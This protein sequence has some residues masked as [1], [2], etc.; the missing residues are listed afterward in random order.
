MKIS[1]FGAA[2]EVGRSCIMVSTDKTRILLDAGVKIGAQDEYPHLDDSMLKDIDGIVVSH[3]H[4]DH[5]GYLPHIYSAGYTG[6]TYVTKPTMELITVLISDYMRISN[7][8]NVTQSGLKKMEAAFRLYEYRKEFRINEL[9]LKF[10]PAGHILGSAMISVSDGKNTLLY[11]G[12]INTAK[13]KLFDG[14]ELKGLNADTLIT[15]STYGAPND[16]FQKEQDIIREMVKSIKETIKVGGKV[17]IPSFAVGRAQEVLLFLDDNINSGALPKVPIYVDGMINKAMRIHRHN[18]I[19]CRKELQ[20][21]ILM[22]EYDP[23]KSKNFVVVDK[24]GTRNKIVTEEESAIIVTTSGMLSGGPVFFYLS[25]L[26]GNSLNKM[27]MV[28]YQAE[29]TLGR[30]M[31]DGNRHITIDKTKIDVQLKVETYHLSAHADRKGLESVM[32]SINGLKNVFIVHGEKSK[33]ESLKEYASKK[34][35]TIVPELEGEYTI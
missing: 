30:E 27:I 1:F 12:D 25:K 6:S 10:I 28:G 31:Q 4:L 34:Y 18:V 21:R 11:T 24:K 13:S 16:A 22:S 33:S 5:S 19:Y 17:I 26:A 15:E 7:P 8:S 29:G 2:G 14:A 20:S 35:K 23:F 3:A 32:S 9:K